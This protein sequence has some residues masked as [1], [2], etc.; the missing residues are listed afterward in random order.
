MLAWKF[1]KSE[2]VELAGGSGRLT[3]SGPWG[4]MPSLTSFLQFAS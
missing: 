3:G 2:K 4:L 1:V